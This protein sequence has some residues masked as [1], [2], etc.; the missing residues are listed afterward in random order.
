MAFVTNYQQQQH[1]V[2]HNINK[3]N[4]NIN[5]KKITGINF[6]SLKK[7]FDTVSHNN[8]QQKL[9]KYGV[10]RTIHNLMESYIDRTQTLC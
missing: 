5:S 2:L 9:G 7:A 1:A 6:L 8:F 3:I 4:N 10:R